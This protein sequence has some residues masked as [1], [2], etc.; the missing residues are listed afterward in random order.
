[1]NQPLAVAI[2]FFALGVTFLGS[3]LILLFNPRSRGGRWWVVFQVGI[4][5]W[6]GV[7]GWAIA[8]GD[9]VRLGPVVS[10]IAH[11]LPALFLA[12]V[13]ADVVR[14]PVGYVLPVL[15]V[16]LLLLPV[17]VA[18]WNRRFGEGVLGLWQLGA[19]GLASVLL[20]VHGRRNLPLGG[21]KRRLGLVVLVLLIVNLPVVVVGQLLYDGRIFVYLMP[22][23]MVEIN[24]LTFVGVVHLQWHD[25][26][27]RAARTGEIAAQT[28]EQERLAVVG[29][30]AASLAHEIRNPLTGARSLAQRLA[31][32]EIGSEQRRRYAAVIL[33]EVGRVERLVANLLGV[34]RRPA[35][36]PDAG[37]ATPLAPLF[38]DLFLLLGSRAAKAGVRLVADGA[39]VEATAPREPLA[40]AVLNLL[41]NAVAHAPRGTAVELTAR[42]A[43]GGVEV[44]VRDGGPGVPPEERERIWE[45]FYTR[46]GGTGLGLAVV[47]RLAREHGWEVAV[48]DA[49]GGGAEFRLRIP[50]APL[51]GHDSAA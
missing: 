17:D 10:G 7:Q 38:D 12:F 48:D 9:W 31:E 4:M 14:K 26:E 6:L 51:A 33:E 1:M 20:W 50:R 5:A 13:L 18:S 8:T 37:A 27:V 19:W 25:I 22:L 21:P 49:P 24:V 41:L 34:A 40:Q 23:L 16:A 36:H 43:E 44:R 29:E 42:E 47:R 30:L 2:A 45:P 32:E 15:A 46:G 3:L 39:A 28:A 35:R 11:L